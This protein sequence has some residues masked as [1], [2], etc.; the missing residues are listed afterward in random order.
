MNRR[1]TGKGNNEI[2]LDLQMTW[3]RNQQILVE[4]WLAFCCSFEWQQLMTRR[5]SKLK[6]RFEYSLLR[7][8]ALFDL[9]KTVASKCKVALDLTH[10]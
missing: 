4:E 1:I 2:M 8:V 10:V 6:T 9:N 3:K 5:G 7:K